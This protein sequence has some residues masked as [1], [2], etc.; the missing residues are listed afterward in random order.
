MDF[1]ENVQEFVSRLIHQFLVD[2]DLLLFDIVLRLLS[3][4]EG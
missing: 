3:A 2:F 4:A 1:T